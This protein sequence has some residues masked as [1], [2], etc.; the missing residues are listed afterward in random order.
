MLLTENQCTAKYEGGSVFQK[1]SY[2]LSNLCF[3]F[4]ILLSKI[5]SLPQT[6]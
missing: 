5:S 4:K 3:Q 6:S 1:H 2:Q